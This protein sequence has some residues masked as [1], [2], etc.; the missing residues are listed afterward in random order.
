MAGRL[1]W[2][3]AALTFILLLVG[4]TVHATGSSLACPDGPL[5]YGELLPPMRG[6]V[7]VEHSHRLLASLVGLLT[8][9]LAALLAWQRLGGWARR[10]AL[11]AV[12]ALLVPPSLLAWGFAGARPP[13][14]SPQLAAWGV[15]S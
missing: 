14:L 1:A 11:A 15:L 3:L 2:G 8:M 4:G 13:P 7:L 9:A 5:C 6:S 10:L 12:G